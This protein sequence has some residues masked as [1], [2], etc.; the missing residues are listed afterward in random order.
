MTVFSKMM[1]LT[2]QRATNKA[3]GCRSSARIA[4]IFPRKTKP[5]ARLYLVILFCGAAAA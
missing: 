4:E 1:P 5:S 2:E 3:Q